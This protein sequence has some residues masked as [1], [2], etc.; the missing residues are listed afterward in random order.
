[1]NKKLLILAALVSVAGAQLMADCKACQ[2]KHDSTREER[3][4]YREEKRKRRKERREAKKEEKKN[5]KH[6]KAMDNE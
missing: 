1:M 3:Q 6:S 2:M 4:E 5:K